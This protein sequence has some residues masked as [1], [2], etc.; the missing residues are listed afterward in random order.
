MM[1]TEVCEGRRDA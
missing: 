1:K